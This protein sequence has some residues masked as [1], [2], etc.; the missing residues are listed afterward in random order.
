MGVGVLTGM[1]QQARGPP[2]PSVGQVK[3]GSG[4]AATGQ[5]APLAQP[6][7]LF[8]TTPLGQGEPVGRGVGMGVLV[9][10][11]VGAGVLVGV[12]VPVGVGVGV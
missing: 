7:D 9:G 3:E 5:E 4:V 8:P 6:Y 12:I 1:E 11:K 2:S 10:V